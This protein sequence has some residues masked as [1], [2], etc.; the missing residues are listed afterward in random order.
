MCRDDIIEIDRSAVTRGHVS[1]LGVLTAVYAQ[2]MTVIGYSLHDFSAVVENNK[3]NSCF[4]S[5]TRL[6]R[7]TKK[8][9]K[10]A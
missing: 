3:H 7:V 2:K 6:S 4:F 5:L 8:K 1:L 10:L 9:K